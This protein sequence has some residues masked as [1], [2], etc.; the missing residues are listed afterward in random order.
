MTLPY[1]GISKQNDK[2]KFEIFGQNT[3]TLCEK[4]VY[5]QCRIMTNYTYYRNGGG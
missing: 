5:L 2:R 4:M 3:L 1:N